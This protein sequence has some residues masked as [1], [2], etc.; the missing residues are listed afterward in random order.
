MYVG[1]MDQWVAR[2]DYDCRW[3]EVT[4]KNVIQNGFKLRFSFILKKKEDNLTTICLTFLD[5]I[6]KEFRSQGIKHF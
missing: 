2:F 1:K 5:L 4:L 6:S 3:F